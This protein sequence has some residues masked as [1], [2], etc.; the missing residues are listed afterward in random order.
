MLPF[1]ITTWWKMY[2]NITIV[3]QQVKSDFDG[4]SAT[5]R[6]VTAGLVSTQTFTLPKNYSIEASL[7]YESPGT[8]GIFRVS[9]FALLNIGGQ[10]KFKDNSTLR[11][12]LSDALS[13]LRYIATLDRPEQ[14]FYTQTRIDFSRRLVSVT[15]T[16]PFG[17]R[18]VTKKRSRSTGSEEETRRIQ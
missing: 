1:T 2:N 11:L 14:Y 8:W 7:N 5:L 10:K 6:A 3:G 15:Y 9:S 16:R 18:E 4:H 13:S 12:N 17:K